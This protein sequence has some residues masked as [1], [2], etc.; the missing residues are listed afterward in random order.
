MNCLEFRQRKLRNPRETFEL[1]DQHRDECSNCQ[2]FENELLGLDERLH[3]AFAIPVPENLDARIL[4]KQSFAGRKRDHRPWR[5]VGIAASLVLAAVLLTAVLRPPSATALE[6]KLV[7]HV[8]TE[9]QM[10]AMRTT[11]FDAATIE[12]ILIEAGI[13]VNVRL[14]DVVHAAPCFIDGTRIAHLIVRNNS[15]DTTVLLTPFE[16]PSRSLFTAAGWSGIVEPASFG[17]VAVLAPGSDNPD[18]LTPFLEHLETSLTT[19]AAGD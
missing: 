19:R 13:D 11:R 15:G 17:A 6:Q 4:L 12:R 1:L 5:W 10:A 2:R 7:A 16:V 9:E 18:R 14:E 3:E 8:G